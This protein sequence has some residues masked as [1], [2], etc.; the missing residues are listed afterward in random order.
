MVIKGGSRS[1]GGNLAAHLLRTDTNERVEVVDLQGVAADRLPEALA[2]MEAVASGTRCRKS[3]YHASINTGPDE[4]L[5]LEQKAAAVARLELA[6]GL[7][8]HARA[9]VEHRKEGRDHLHV[10]WSRID[11]DT[12]RAAHDGHNYRRHE[13][14][15]RELEREFGHNRVQGVHHERET[16][17]GDKRPR[18]PRTPSPG[19]VQQATRTKREIGEVGAE[20]TRLWQQTD[21]GLAFTAAISEAGYE[22]ARGDR[23]G[24]VV[25]DQAGGVHSLARRIEGAKTKDVATRLAGIDLDG[26]P[27]TDQ[28]RAVQQDRQAVR[29]SLALPAKERPAARMAGELTRPAP[30]V[31][32]PAL[33]LAG[34]LAPDSAQKTARD[35]Q[36]DPRTRQPSPGGR[37]AEG[38]ISP[39]TTLPAPSLEAPERPFYAPESPAAA[40]EPVLPAID[41]RNGPDVQQQ[42]ADS[43][44]YQRGQHEARDRKRSPARPKV[45]PSVGKETA[46]AAG[47]AAELAGQVAGKGFR[48]GKGLFGGL[49]GGLFKGASAL[50]GR[51]AT[52]A[53]REQRP[54]PQEPAKPPERQRPPSLMDEM[55]KEIRA[56]AAA[57]PGRRRSRKRSAT[58][59]GA[60]SRPARPPAFWGRSLLATGWQTGM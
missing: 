24:F 52:E 41:R 11:V 34:D 16:T 60:G 1:G 18:P 57:A 33:D 35:L 50:A 19:D 9:V 30:Q 38:P 21:S 12:M 3:L 58:G 20:L 48:A 56:K 45:Q 23:R 44:E 4:E 27:S 26:L 22:L 53:D 47:K 13:E 25:I 37:Q 43:A 36:A 14:V 6:L 40:P 5:T 55:E 29:D 10:V 2:E 7:E 15:A 28:A 39:A 8:G 42:L 17:E 59:T 54:P 32:M 31:A 51:P 49:L 46:R